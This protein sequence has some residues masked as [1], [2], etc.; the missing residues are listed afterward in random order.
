M[1]HTAHHNYILSQA[2]CRLYE[3][4]YV[5][6]QSTPGLMNLYCTNCLSAIQ[7]RWRPSI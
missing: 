6:R 4:R 3:P 5:V 2:G 1:K 7:P